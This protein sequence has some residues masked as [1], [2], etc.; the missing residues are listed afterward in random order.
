MTSGSSPTEPKDSEEPEFSVTIVAFNNADTIAESVQRSLRIP[1]CRS[2]VVVD[3]G[4]DGTASV[5]AAAGAVSIHRPDNPGFGASQNT[6]VAATTTPYVLLLNPDAELIADAPP[7]GIAWLEADHRAGAAQGVVTS[8]R[9]GMPERSMGSD[10][11]WIHLVGRALAARRLLST[12]AGRRLARL[13]GLTDHVERVPATPSRVETLAATAILVRRAAFDQV[14]G[15][16]ERYFLYGEDLDLCRRLRR[17]GWSLVGLPVPWAFHTDGSTAASPYERELAWWNGT[18]Q[19]AALWWGGAQ[20]T[21][22][23]LAASLQCCRLV[24]AHPRSSVRSIRVVL[25]EPL[26][27]RRSQR[28]TRRP[29]GDD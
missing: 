10:V 14:G 2:V 9:T 29:A 3:N 28:A 17:A 21:A 19:Y 4:S 13:A 27:C 15:F 22:A 24:A 5:A 1:G 16:D 11:R 20:W 12:R 8:R 18:M 6:A 26:Q 23:I 7:A 25:I